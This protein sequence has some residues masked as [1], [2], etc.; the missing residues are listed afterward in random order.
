[1]LYLSS[2]PADVETNAPNS[3]CPGVSF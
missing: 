1:L 3:R 2:L